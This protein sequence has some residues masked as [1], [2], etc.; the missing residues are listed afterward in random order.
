MPNRAA[1]FIDGAYLSNVL[2]YE[3]NRAKIDYG[4]LARELSQDSEILRTYYYDCPPFQS[5]EPTQEERTRYSAWRKFYTA[6]EN[7]P[8]FE[9]RLG[10]LAYRGTDEEGKPIYIQK[11]VDILLGIDFM[12]LSAKHRI[13]EA[14]LLAGDSDFIPAVEAA[15]SEGV[16]VKLVHGTSPSKDLLQA[17]DERKQLDNALIQSVQLHATSSL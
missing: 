3:H 7:L 9:C 10:R 1:I 2:L 8:R 4:A 5:N 14:V 6:L 16:S 15:K 11:R 13:E 17:V 12:S